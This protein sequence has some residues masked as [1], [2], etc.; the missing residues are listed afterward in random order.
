MNVF[1]AIMFILFFIFI[2]Y[3][4]I[5]N[6]QLCGYNIKF[7]FKHIFSFPYEFKGKNKLAWTKRLTR[8]V[9]LYFILISIITLIYFIFLSSFW[10]IALFVIIEF[11]FLQFILLFCALLLE[12]FEFLIK[13]YYIFKTCKKLKNFKGVKIAITGSF[14]KTSTKNFLEELL[15]SKYKVCSTPKNFNTPMGLCKTVLDLLKPDDE[16]LIVEMGARKR[17]DIAE[18]MKMVDPDI[19]II[20]HI[21]EQHL[22]SFGNL[23]NIKKTKYEMCEH[24]NKQGKIIFD[25]SSEDTFDL[26]KKYFGKKY[27]VNFKN[28]FCYVTDLKCSHKGCNFNLHINHQQFKAQTKIVG[29]YMIFNIASACAVASLLGIEGDD[30]IKSILKIKPVKHRL[31]LIENAN[32]II[33]DDSYN[34]NL[35]GGEQACEC[36]DLFKGK[37]IVISPGLVEQGNKQYELNYRLGKIIGEKCHQFIIMNEI[38]KKA[39]YEG[40]IAGGMQKNNIFFAQTREEQVALIKRLQD[41]NCVILFENDLPDIFK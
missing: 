5:K 39:L 10:L 7:Y 36:L 22:E 30:L 21:G 32:F 9:I 23:D 14:G 8:L 26:F 27:S 25:C 3:P 17:G 11:L 33:I 35:Y 29:K 24:M 15:K 6:F 38:N 4:F 16:V 12:P 2:S 18:L 19:G 34:S 20:T 31:E 41:K 1:F 28:S 13:K 37:K 40:A